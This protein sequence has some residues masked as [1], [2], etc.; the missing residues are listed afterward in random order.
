MHPHSKPDLL[1]STGADE[2]H[3]FSQFC[4]P[5]ELSRRKGRRPGL[6]LYWFTGIPT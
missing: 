6:S 2:F 3:G 4:A 1:S 5:L